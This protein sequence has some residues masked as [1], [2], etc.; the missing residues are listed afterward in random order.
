MNNQ[1]VFTIFLAVLKLT[2][3]VVLPWWLV[4]APLWFPPVLQAVNR[5]LKS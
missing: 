4:L 5:L 2:K 3:V 1:I